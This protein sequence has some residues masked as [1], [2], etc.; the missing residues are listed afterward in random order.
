MQ[1]SCTFYRNCNIWTSIVR[2]SFAESLYD[3]GKGDQDEVRIDARKHRQ[4]LIE[5]ASREFAAKGHM[6]PLQDVLS[7]AGLGRG[8][9]YRHFR[10]RASLIMAVITFELGRTL[11]DVKKRSGDAGLLADFLETQSRCASVHLPAISS[12]DG[13]RLQCF[14]ENIE[15]TLNSILES[16]LESARQAGQARPDVSIDDLKLAIKMLSTAGV[17]Y[18]SGDGAEPLARAINMILRG[19]AP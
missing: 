3:D 8:T 12:W 9:L 18:A 2:L 4:D 10:D 11:E 13:E 19:L 7:E 5:A 14:I 17:S 1:V 15:P 6:A 16:V